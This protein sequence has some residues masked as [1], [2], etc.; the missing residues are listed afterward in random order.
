VDFEKPSWVNCS[1]CQIRYDLVA[2][3]GGSP[4]A[5]DFDLGSGTGGNGQTF[6]QKRKKRCLSTQYGWDVIP[7]TWSP[8]PNPAACLKE[9]SNTV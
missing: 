7:G 1:T 9:L 6:V 3:M 4:D 8:L 2:V 5:I